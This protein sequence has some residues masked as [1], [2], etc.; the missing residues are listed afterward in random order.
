[1]YK[2]PP[3]IGPT[4]RTTLR[5]FI[6]G[7]LLNIALVIG[8][9]LLKTHADLII[10]LFFN[11]NPWIGMGYWWRKRG[12]D[13]VG[14]GCLTF[15]IVMMVSIPVLFICLWFSYSMLCGC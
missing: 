7:A 1:M 3:A 4:K 10:I 9:A 6:V 2:S 8:T 15:V 12:L 5:L 13:G 11:P 14:W